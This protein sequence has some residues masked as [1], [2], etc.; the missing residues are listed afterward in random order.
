MA[1]K[2]ANAP[3]E[4][5]T[6]GQSNRPLSLPAH[7]LTSAQVEEE[8]GGNSLNGLA[9]EEAAKRIEEFGKN[10]LGDAEGVQPLRIVLAQIANAM[11]MVSSGVREGGWLR[12]RGE[13][14]CCWDWGERE[15]YRD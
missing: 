7:A 1:K 8:L 10:E 3:A 12:G 9:P 5:H 15:C 14:E 2:K 6:S 11:T 4:G 13:G